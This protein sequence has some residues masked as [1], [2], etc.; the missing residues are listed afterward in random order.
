MS[1]GAP[2][3][4]IWKGAVDFACRGRRPARESGES[5][6][7]TFFPAAHSC[8][9]RDGAGRLVHELT[10]GRPRTWDGSLRQRTTEAAA[11]TGS[12]Y[13]DLCI[14]SAVLT[15]RLLCVRLCQ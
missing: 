9:Q 1:R 3:E 10:R 12:E 5:I 11:H 13:H 7:Q 2:P 6:S 15:I 8:V 14:H 4:N